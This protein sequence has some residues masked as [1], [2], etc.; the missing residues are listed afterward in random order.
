[1]S[2]IVS[3]IVSGLVSYNKSCPVWCHVLC[4]QLCPVLYCVMSFGQL[5]NVPISI[6]FMHT[7]NQ[8]WKILA[9]DNGVQI[10]EDNSTKT[11]V[12]DILSLTWLRKFPA[13]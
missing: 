6:K 8:D 11:F 12:D 5:N 10:K 7:M 1:M 2:C 4:P 9:I 13:F 3:Y